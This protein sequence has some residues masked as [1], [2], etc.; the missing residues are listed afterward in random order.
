MKIIDGVIFKNMFLAGARNLELN[1]QAVDSLNV[2]PV[3]DGDTGTN[4]TLT[5]LSAEEEL[6]DIDTTHIGEVAKAISNGT[7]KGAR[8]NSGVILSQLFR[9]FANHIKD[10]ATIDAKALAGAFKNGVDLAYKAVL[11]PIEGT[12]LTVTREAANK[13][14]EY[15]QVTD[16]VEE[17]L[18]KTINAAR[19]TLD[20]TPEMLPSLK[21][22]GVVDSGGMGYI[23]I[24]EGFYSFLTK[25]STK[26]LKKVKPRAV[27]KEEI[28]FAYCTEISVR[29]SKIGKSKIPNFRMMLEKVGDSLV[30]VE[31]NEIVKIHVHTNNPDEVLQSGLQLGELVKIKI[32]N[33]KEQHTSFMS[34]EEPKEYGFV[35]VAT[36]EGVKKIFSS[37]MVDQII[38][39]GQ[40]MNPSIEDILKAI[41]LIN[42]RNI[43]V[44]P[45]NSNVIMAANQ[46]KELSDKNVIVV[47][48]KNIPQGV[49]AMVGFKEDLDWKKNLKNFGNIISKLKTASVTYSIRDSVFD[50]TVI[51]KGDYLGII[52]G[53]IKLT[54]KDLNETAINVVSEIADEDKFL[55]IIYGSDTNEENL[56]SLT[57]FIASNYP[58]WEFEIHNGGQPIYNY[59]FSV[60]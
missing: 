45:N 59:I 44:F 22:A 53:K 56:D 9:G 42:A 23:C 36:G 2:F 33:M 50:D 11:K 57:N 29:P 46:A 41:N 27:A 28:V 16:E 3:P 60:E 6:K 7:L 19:S 18:E 20:R 58:E 30:L 38:D 35:T 49:S 32:E 13:A 25:S 31:D 4:M 37:L 43:F 24:L 5:L 47:P 21:Q 54:G 51:N 8:G 52:E 12:I 15:A 17:V 48:T 14:I 26:L 39:G 34:T 10:L 55:T 1:K 40:T